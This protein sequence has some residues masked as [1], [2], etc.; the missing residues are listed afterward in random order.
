M[1]RK[2]LVEVF[3]YFYYIVATVVLVSS[4]LSLIKILLDIIHK[5]NFIMGVFMQENL[6]YIEHGAN[7]AQE[8]MKEHTTFPG[9]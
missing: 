5:L 8:S 7:H 6:V 2:H 9:F 3:N 1:T 4:V